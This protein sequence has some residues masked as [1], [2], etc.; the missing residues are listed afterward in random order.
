MPRRVE[1]YR[2]KNPE[3]VPNHTFLVAPIV[4]K[5]YSAKVKPKLKETDR[6]SSYREFT[7][8]REYTGPDYIEVKNKVREAVERKRIAPSPK[9]ISDKVM[10]SIPTYSEINNGL[11]RKRKQIMRGD[12]V[13]LL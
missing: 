12:I 5:E 7:K 8:S 9:V 1:Q 6:W 4:H 3:S 10:A 13:R 2:E 11:E